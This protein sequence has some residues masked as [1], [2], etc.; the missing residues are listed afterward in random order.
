MRRPQKGKSC[1]SVVGISAERFVFILIVEIT[2]VMGKPNP[3]CIDLL[4]A[5]GISRLHKPGIKKAACH[6]K[7]ARSK[8]SLKCGTLEAKGQKGC[9]PYPTRECLGQQLPQPYAKRHPMT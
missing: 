2:D 8:L 1:R 6:S 3:H 7:A 5:V 4:P 9:W